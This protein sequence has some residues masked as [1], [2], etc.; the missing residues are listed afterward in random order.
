[1]NQSKELCFRWPKPETESK[2]RELIELEQFF[3]IL[4]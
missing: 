3:S 4:P 1:L 2:V